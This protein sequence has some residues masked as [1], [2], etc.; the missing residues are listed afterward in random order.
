[1]CGKIK[2]TGGFLANERGTVALIFGLSAFVIFGGV[3]LAIDGGRAYQASTRTAVAL[4]ASA[5]AAAK[6]MSE[7]GLTG[8]QLQ[9]FA[10]NFFNVNVRGTGADPTRY[11]NFAVTSDPTTGEV[12]TT[13]ETQV[14]TTFAGIFA[15]PSIDFTSSATAIYNIK[16]IELSM[17]LD[18]TGSMCNPC[19]KIRDL[20]AASKDLV[21]ILIDPNN[22]A[23]TVKIGLAPYSAAVNAGGYAGRV[24]DPRAPSRD[25]CVIERGAGHAY[26]DVAPAPG[27]W[28]STAS[29]RRG[30]RDIDPTQ[31]FGSYRCP[32]AR[33]LP[34]SQ[35]ARLIKNRIDS[36]RTGGW[37]S[38][39]LGLAWAWYLVSPNWANIWPGSAQ[40]V[41]YGDRDTVKAV[42][43]MTD[44]IFNTAYQNGN[45]D[46]QARALCTQ[47][48]QDGVT[49]FAVA[50]QAP[51][52]ASQL[53]RDCSTPPGNGLGQT[54]FNAAN[55]GDLRHAFRTVAAQLNTL[56][57]AR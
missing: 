18:V 53:L 26:D 23:R 44:G 47:M 6:A 29:G 9:Q 27:A 57:L 52:S 51:N 50:F 30:P 15:I 5:L 24:T 56:R 25:G 38:G 16:D 41:A 32:N 43:L 42:L 39:H 10:E 7:Q 49:V 8:T 4:D 45:S 13:V 14:P 12:T 22:R 34:L 28:L 40:P 11:R 1:M 48:K 31:G 17:M 55:G 19:S 33:I 46:A 2:R 20:K 54:F 3:G 35:D 36:F 37:T 21:D